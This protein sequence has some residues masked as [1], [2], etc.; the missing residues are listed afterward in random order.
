V[1]R[2]SDVAPRACNV[3]TGTARKSQGIPTTRAEVCVTA[4]PIPHVGAAGS[5]VSPLRER[6]RRLSV[7]KALWLLWLPC[8][9]LVPA[10]DGATCAGDYAADTQ[11]QH[12]SEEGNR[13]PKSPLKTIARAADV[14]PADTAAGGGLKPWRLGCTY[15]MSDR[16]SMFFSFLSATIVAVVCSRSFRVGNGVV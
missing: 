8:A 4:A 5:R 7:L 10:N 3:P 11:N 12:A 14:V 6:T 15:P 2:A 16:V 9:A 13:T 1:K